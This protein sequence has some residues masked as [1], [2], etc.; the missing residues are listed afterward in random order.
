MFCVLFLDCLF[1]WVGGCF[2]FVRFGLFVVGFLFVFCCFGGGGGG[3]ILFL[4]CAVR[5]FSSCHRCH[6][7]TNGDVA[8]LVLTCHLGH[9]NNRATNSALSSSLMSDFQPRHLPTVAFQSISA[10]R[11]AQHAA[12]HLLVTC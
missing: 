10:Q 11:V 2:A 12:S 8:R 5:Y 7:L 4:F 1:V 9:D 6:Y 3:D